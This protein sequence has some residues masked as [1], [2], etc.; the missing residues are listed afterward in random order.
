V[1]EGDSGDRARAVYPELG[2]AVVH[3]RADDIPVNAIVPAWLSPA[4]A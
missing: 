4:L 2:L 1:V 3:S